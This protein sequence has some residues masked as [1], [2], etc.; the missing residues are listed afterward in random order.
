LIAKKDVVLLGNPGDGKTHLI[1][2]VEK[3]TTRSR[4]EFVLDATAESD[5]AQLVRR[6][7]VS[8]RAKRPFCLAINQG[9][10]SQL[11]AH[12]EVDV[13]QL[14]E[15]R[16]QTRSLVYYDNVP[17]PPGKVVVVDLN[18]R[19]V[20]TPA[21]IQRALQ[22][23][24][25]PGPL[26]ACPEC[27]GDETSDVSL[28]RRAISEPQ[29][30]ER[31]VQLLTAAAHTGRHIS[32]RDL[33]GFLSFMLL[34]GRTKAEIV[35][36]PS[37]YANRYFTLCF[38]GEG[39]L[40]DAVRDVFEPERATLPGVDEHLWENTGVQTGWLFGRPQVTP[41]HLDDAYE[42]FKS[43]KRQY[44]FEHADGSK[45]LSLERDDDSVFFSALS[46]GATYTEQFLPR[47]LRAINAFFCPRLDEDGSA[48]RLWGSQQYDTH[49]PRVLVSCYR[50][51]REKFTLLVPKLAPWLEGAM[52]YRADHLFL[53]YKGKPNDN[54]GLRIDRGMW[55]ALA[56]AERGMPMSL[57]S[58]QYAK[59]LQTF[60]TRL[61]GR[62]ASPQLQEQ[63]WSY[64]VGLDRLSSI[65]VDRDREVYAQ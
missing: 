39:E 62:E 38:E 10:L 61:Y 46:K 25:Q 55:R 56:L 40:F 2:R 51:P 35:R 33:Q 63:V 41:D 8:T 43:L 18:L 14:G 1:R 9:P 48:L 6:W 32:M 59:A 17:K 7:R 28:N 52:D 65:K 13:P 42:L 44:F 31:I 60:I 53:R 24:L 47:V 57:R 50:V 5:Y 34:G 30:Q 20:L 58:P 4:P 27:F 26:D 21:I 16:D 37:D 49:S 11:L 54:I 29:V 19:S 22:N 23:I 15:V 3:A 45:L 12:K 64:N 36:E